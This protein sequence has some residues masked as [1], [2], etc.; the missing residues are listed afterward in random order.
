MS[1]H[2]PQNFL[3]K[4]ALVDGMAALIRLMAWSHAGDQSSSRL[5]MVCEI[6]STFSEITY[7][8]SE[9]DVNG[10]SIWFRLPSTMRSFA[11]FSFL[12][13]IYDWSP[14]QT[15]CF[16]SCIKMDHDKWVTMVK[17]LLWRISVT[18]V[19]F[20]WTHFSTGPS[21]PS[22]HIRIILTNRHNNQVGFQKMY[23]SK[24]LLFS[25]QRNGFMAM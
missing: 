18:F 1:N 5:F 9:T 6:F 15:C 14:L 3:I 23:F 19:T 20:V 8:L 13:Q 17:Y 2:T 16:F 4:W 10:W 24:S 12:V 21:F 25:C 11:R 7:K 22:A